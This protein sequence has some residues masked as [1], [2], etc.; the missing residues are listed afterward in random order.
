MSLRVWL[1]LTGDFHNQGLDGNISITNYGSVFDTAG[2]I[3]NSCCSFDGTDDYFQFSNLNLNGLE[4]LSISFWAYSTTGTLNGLFLIRNSSTQHQIRISG[5]SFMFRDKAH[6][7]QQIVPFTQPTENTWTHYVVIYDNGS[8]R[9]FKDGI[10]DTEKIYS[11]TS[12]LNSNLADMR[13]GRQQSSTNN[14]YYTG[15]LND[16]RIYDHA[17]SDKEIKEI[18]KGLV[19]HWELKGNGFENKNLFKNS[20]LSD[21]TS[22]NLSSKIRYASTYPPEITNDGVK[23]T[24]SSSS[25]RE[26]GLWLDENLK[27]DTDYTLSFTYKSNMQIGTSFYLR[28]GNALVG[29]WSQA[30]IPQS[31]N[32]AHYTCTFKP[33]SYQSGDITKGNSLTLFYSGYTANKWI[34]LKQNSIKLEEGIQSTSWCPA[35]S[36]DINLNIPNNIIYDSSGYNHNGTIIG[37]AML[38]FTSPRYGIATYMNNNSSANRI[39]ADPIVLPVDGITVSFWAYTTKENSYVL[40]IDQNM[41]F[42]VNA[43]GTGFWVSRVNSKGFPTDSFILG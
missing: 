22:S 15:K 20:S 14:I 1:P 42:A 29:Y 25:A 2:K 27:V 9:V 4:E 34:E 6:S 11:A 3:A 21:L 16:F 41:S 24:W 37:T 38:D 12:S 36:D 30:T 7:A 13:V 35:N 23:F 26:L 28:N 5:D 40:Y 33:I 32:W 43:A 19:L 18:S 8:V 31:T 10:K 17:L 39:E